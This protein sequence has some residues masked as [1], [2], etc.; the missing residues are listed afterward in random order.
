LASDI[1]YITLSIQTFHS[2][3][4]TTVRKVY[5]HGRFLRTED[6]KKNNLIVWQNKYNIYIIFRIWRRSWTS[7]T[8]AIGS[9]QASN[10]S[11]RQYRLRNRP[12][13]CI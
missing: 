7:V 2:T 4:S 1:L 11:G 3:A 10:A 13:I 5:I 8:H 12:E 6:N 9:H